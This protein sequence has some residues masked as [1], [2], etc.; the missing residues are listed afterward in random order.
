MVQK[1]KENI[2]ALFIAKNV[3]VCTEAK[4]NLHICDIFSGKW[5]F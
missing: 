3:I 1:N 5:L 4:A 2:T